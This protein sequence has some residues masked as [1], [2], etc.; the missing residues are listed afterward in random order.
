MQPNACQTTAVGCLPP[1]YWPPGLPGDSWCSCGTAALESSAMGRPGRLPRSRLTGTTATLS[2]AGHSR[3][4]G[5]DA[6]SACA[7][8]LASSAALP[9]P[10]RV[11]P[12]PRPATPT[13]NPTLIP[14]PATR[15]PL[16]ARVTLFTLV[17]PPRGASRPRFL[18]PTSPLGGVVR[19]GRN[20]ML[21][22]SPL[23]ARAITRPWSSLGADCHYQGVPTPRR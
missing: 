7:A 3:W 15:V 10:A 22:A 11:P 20:E 1:G 9:V 13:R 21:T 2:A 5:G 19:P 6:P 12:W 17:M 14:T 4:R 8:S 18:R 16:P 23:R